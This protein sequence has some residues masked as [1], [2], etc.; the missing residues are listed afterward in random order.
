V[1]DVL[2]IPLFPEDD[3]KSRA[4]WASN[5]LHDDDLDDIVQRQM[6]FHAAWRI[7]A[8]RGLNTLTSPNSLYHFANNRFDGFP[9]KND[10][11]GSAKPDIIQLLARGIVT[12]IDD[13][14][15]SPKKH[16]TRAELCGLFAKCIAAPAVIDKF[17]REMLREGEKVRIYLSPA[18]HNYINRCA[19]PGTNC[20]SNVPCNNTTCNSCCENKHAN[21]YIDVL[22]RHLTACGFDTKRRPRSDRGSPE[23]NQRIT[24]ANSWSA[25]LYYAC[26]TD[27]SANGTVRGSRPQVNSDTTNQRHRTSR[28]WSEIVLKW[29]RQIYDQLCAVHTHNGVGEINF[30][31]MPYIYEELVFHDNIEDAA[32]LHRNMDLLAEYT[33]RALCEI[34]RLQYRT[35]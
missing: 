10:V 19:Y 16:L 21:A 14:T 3:E 17:E 8:S 13:G 2:D 11:C 27:A 12:G 31:N 20:T 32:F 24:E 6:A 30:T 34:F 4:G 9:D 33:A 25:D 1:R 5:F 22:E 23:Y 7:V 29:R 28:E 18:D 26:H 15:L 35:P